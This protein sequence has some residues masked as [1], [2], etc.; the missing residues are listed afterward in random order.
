M[1]LSLMGTVVSA[2]LLASANPAAAATL[3]FTANATLSSGISSPYYPFQILGVIEFAPTTGSSVAQGD[4]VAHYGAG[5]MTLNY[6][7]GSP[8]GLTDIVPIN[9]FVQQDYS[10]SGQVHDWISIGTASAPSQATYQAISFHMNLF[11][12]TNL[13]G[14]ES[15][16][17]AVSVLTSPSSIASLVQTG[18][19]APTGYLTAWY[20]TSVTYGAMTLAA[21]V[22]PVPAAMWLLG[23]GLLGL[24]SVARRRRS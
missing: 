20:S 5:T 17:D 14:G 1:K 18:T 19:F 11:G 6:V 21:P 15:F 3:T 13:L 23:S 22:V 4:G 7:G 8:N 24:V 9:L 16:A 10:A 2:V 12:D